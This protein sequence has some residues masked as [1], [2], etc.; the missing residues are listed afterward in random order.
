MHTFASVTDF[1]FLN[2][3]VLEQIEIANAIISQQNGHIYVVCF[4]TGIVQADLSCPP[5]E[6][7]HN[8]EWSPPF[9]LSVTT[10]PP[11]CS[12]KNQVIPPKILRPPQVINND[13]S[14]N[15]WLQ[16][17]RLTFL[18][19]RIEHKRALNLS[20]SF[21]PVLLFPSSLTPNSKSSKNNNNKNRTTEI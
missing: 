8:F 1:R 7:F 6:S 20:P 19:H 18:R 12:P 16:V 2:K 5:S 4:Q 15:N 3:V 9:G 10:D 13:R 14:L 17:I 11:L 21:K